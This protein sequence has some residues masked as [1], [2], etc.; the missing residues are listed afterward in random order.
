LVRLLCSARSIDRPLV[1]VVDWSGA[2]SIVALNQLTNPPTTRSTAA[3]VPCQ[4][5]DHRT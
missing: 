2:M 4:S 5:I 3:R 1:V